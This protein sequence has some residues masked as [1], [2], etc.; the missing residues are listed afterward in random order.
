MVE[1]ETASGLRVIQ[2]E[3]LLDAGLDTHGWFD[4]SLPSAMF[5]PD[6]PFNDDTWIDDNETYA[7]LKGACDVIGATAINLVRTR[8]LLQTNRGMFVDDRN[9]FAVE[10]QKATLPGGC[11]IFFTN[12]KDV[13][14]TIQ[15]ADCIPAI[16]YAPNKVLSIAHAG[17]M[18]TSK[19]TLK[20]A[21]ELLDNCG[22]EPNE[23]FVALGPSIRDNYSPTQARD[24]YTLDDIRSSKPITHMNGEVEIYDII[25]TNI[26]QLQEAGIPAEQIDMSVCL[27]TRTAKNPDGTDRFYSYDR[28]FPRD[29]Y[30]K[31]A[32]DRLEPNARIAYTKAIAAAMRRNTTI[33][34]L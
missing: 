12:H 29:Q 31:D 33:A 23:I 1:L 3:L 16:L 9:A 34:Q 24:N 21:V 25:A 5:R 17:G 20:R 2:S 28:D 13:P 18:G 6:N 19:Q 27:D 14:I 26:R 32:L 8:G 30:G 4:A 11:D 7:V 15:T 22:V 10:Q